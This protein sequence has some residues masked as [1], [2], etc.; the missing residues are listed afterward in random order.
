MPFLAVGRSEPSEP[1][2]SA[3]GPTVAED[4]HSITHLEPVSMFFCSATGAGASLLPPP[5]T[6]AM[7][8]VERIVPRALQMIERYPSAFLATRFRLLA[9]R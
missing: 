3:T 6:M 9:A 8:A 7:A 5:E 1:S 4:E 2:F